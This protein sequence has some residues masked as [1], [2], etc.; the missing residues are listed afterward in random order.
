MRR[1]VEWSCATAWKNDLVDRLIDM[2]L[3]NTILAMDEPKFQ[4]SLLQP[5]LLY[6]V[7]MY[8]IFGRPQGRHYETWL[9]LANRE[10]VTVIKDMLVEEYQ[11]EVSRRDSIMTWAT[12]HVQRQAE[13]QRDNLAGIEG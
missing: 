12:Q 7:V 2:G 6:T 4:D 3:K 1:W 9:P 10:M 8:N 13:R 5:R 11:L